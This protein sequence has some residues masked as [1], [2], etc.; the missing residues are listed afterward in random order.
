[1]HM[2][3]AKLL[4]DKMEKMGFYYLLERNVPIVIGEVYPPNI[5]RY[6]QLAGS[7]GCQVSQEHWERRE[8]TL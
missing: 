8:L 7:M 1:M 4:K 2:I 3:V 6:G 5:N